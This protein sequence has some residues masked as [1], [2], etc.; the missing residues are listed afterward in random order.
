M[1]LM[2]GGSRK[3]DIDPLKDA[4]SPLINPEKWVTDQM[5]SLLDDG[6]AYLFDQLQ[7]HVTIF[8]A[9]TY[10]ETDEEEYR[11]EWQKLQ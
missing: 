10:L 2:I 6:C 7:N 4:F 9:T 1:Q 3:A 8:D 5:K 11:G